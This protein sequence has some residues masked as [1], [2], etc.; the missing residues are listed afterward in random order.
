[1]CSTHFYPPNFEKA[2]V[3]TDKCSNQALFAMEHVL[4]SMY[5]LTELMPD[6]SV[7]GVIHDIEMFVDGLHGHSTNFAKTSLL[8]RRISLFVRPDD[9]LMARCQNGFRRRWQ[10][11]ED[12]IRTVLEQ[13]QVCYSSE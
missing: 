8:V 4:D 2:G 10:S 7:L 3:F 9:K 1:M 13:A 11:I 6:L 5:C 12:P